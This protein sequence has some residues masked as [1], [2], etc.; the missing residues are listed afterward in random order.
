MGAN[1][2]TGF[3]LI[4]ILSR[5]G[6]VELKYLASRGNA[7]EGVRALYPSLSGL[8]DKFCDLDIARIAAGSDVVF[9]C[10]PHAAASETVAALCR[11]NPA[12]KII[13][14]S[15]DF[16]Y[17]DLSVYE[18]IYNVKH[19]APDIL[20]KSAY[21]LCEL[22]REKIAVAQAVGNPGCYTTCAI[23]ALYPL[24][25]EKAADTRNIIIDAKSGVSGAGRRSETAYSFCETEG[26][27]KAYSVANHRHTSEI[28]E[29]LSGAANDKITLTFT[30]HLLPVK[31]GILSTIYAKA[32]VSESEIHKIYAKYYENEPFIRI[33][34]CGNMPEIK[35]VAHSN[36]FMLGYKSDPRTGNLIVV[37]VLDNLIK[38]ASGQA[39]QNMNIMFGLKESE[40]LDFTGSYL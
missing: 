9:S 37:A 20:S 33:L 31:R 36:N 24:I 40:G 34:P 18:S 15:A 19:A 38:G 30:P 25:A 21:G 2:Y 32:L 11:E 7:G 10:L 6:K 4:K 35:Y 39:V 5:H 16:R 23:L 26:N 28:E 13:D 27:F 29:K 14:L 1:G 22:Y 8:S 17:N 12:L 3:E